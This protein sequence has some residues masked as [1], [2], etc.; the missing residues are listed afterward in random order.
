[1]VRVGPGGLLLVAGS[2][3]RVPADPAGA[4]PHF[5]G[6]SV[7]GSRTAQSRGWPWLRGPEI[8]LG[9]SAAQA[10]PRRPRSSHLQD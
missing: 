3:K 6:L 2:G 9:F 8:R 4:R 7:W 1:M 10:E 5:R